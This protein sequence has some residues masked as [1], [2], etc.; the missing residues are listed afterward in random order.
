LYNDDATA[1]EVLAAIRSFRSDANGNAALPES[2]P[3]WRVATGM[4]A[5]VVHDA[6]AGSLI[7][8]YQITGRIVSSFPAKSATETIPVPSEGVYIV[9]TGDAAVKVL[10]R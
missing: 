4:R 9:R 1:G 10:V 6:P 8:V 3:A 5:V 7:T 2:R